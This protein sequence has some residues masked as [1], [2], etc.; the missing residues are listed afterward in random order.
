MSGVV[1]LAV[2]A[3]G[4]CADDRAAE[5]GPGGTSLGAVEQGDL[6]DR[7]TP[8]E[9]SDITGGSFEPGETTPAQPGRD[10]GCFA[11]SPSTGLVVTVEVWSERDGLEDDLVRLGSPAA[12]TPTTEVTVAGSPALSATAEIEGRQMADLA[13]DVGDRVLVVLVQQYAVM[14][15][16]VTVEDGTQRAIAIAEA[17]LATS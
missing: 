4:G 10:D 9:L 1:A 14:A 8:E 7:L 5:G 17:L 6:C 15:E 2:L 3:L 11:P 16:G 12:S 13:V